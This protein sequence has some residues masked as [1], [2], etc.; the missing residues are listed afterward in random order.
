[1]EED[2]CIHFGQYRA[3]LSDTQIM[4]YTPPRGHSSQKSACCQA[5]EPTEVSKYF[6]S[7]MI[8]CFGPKN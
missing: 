5:R 8:N 7:Q 1:M 2:N 3:P 6:E 4:T